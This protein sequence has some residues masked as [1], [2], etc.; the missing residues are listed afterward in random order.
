M[1]LLWQLPSVGAARTQQAALECY[2]QICHRL[3]FGVQLIFGPISFTLIAGLDSL[4]FGASQVFPPASISNQIGHMTNLGSLLG[5]FLPCLRT[6][7]LLTLFIVLL[8][9]SKVAFSYSVPTVY[10][11]LELM[12]ELGIAFKEFFNHVVHLLH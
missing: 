7:I 8:C 6:C 1:P 2:T 10:E 3:E 11:L 9:T 4:M 5:L 12:G